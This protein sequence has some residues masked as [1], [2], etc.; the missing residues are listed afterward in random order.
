MILLAMFNANLSQQGGSSVFYPL[1]SRKG[2]SFYLKPLVEVIMYIVFVHSKA[3]WCGCYAHCICSFDFLFDSF[4][5]FAVIVPEG[6][7][8]LAFHS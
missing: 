2:K 1:S 4:M 6:Q 8:F 7:S 5:S 3:T